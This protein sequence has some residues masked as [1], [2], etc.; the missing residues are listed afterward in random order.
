MPRIVLNK[1]TPKAIL[2]GPLEM[3]GLNYPQFEAIQTSR[4]KVYMIKQLIWEKDMY[5]DLRVNIE[6]TQSMSGLELPV[7]EKVEV[8]VKYIPDT[9]ILMVRERMK[10]IKAEMWIEDTCYPK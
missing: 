3:G 9:W 7:I 10:D 1:N 5:E 8:P 2:Y 4:S 6:M